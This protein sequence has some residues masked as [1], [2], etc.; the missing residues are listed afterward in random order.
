[1]H[2][3]GKKVSMLYNIIISGKWMDGSEFLSVCSSDFLDAPTRML[4]LSDGS[5]TLLLNASLLSSVRLQRLRQEEVSLD[6]DMAEYIE[7]EAGQTVIDRDVW[8]MNGEKRVVYANSIL[9]TSLMKDEIYNEIAKGDTPIG[10]LLSE[11]SILTR[12]DRLQ[13]GRIMSLEIC[14]ELG[15]PDATVLWARRY[16]LHTEGGF[17]GAITEVFSPKIFEGSN[18]KGKDQSLT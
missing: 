11:Q 2:I 12:R 13:I 8:L 1:M 6:R 16:R 5:L 18:G 4:L 7:A 10:T 17:K 9:P 15:L 14:R 3:K